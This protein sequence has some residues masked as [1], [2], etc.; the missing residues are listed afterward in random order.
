M[1]RHRTAVGLVVLLAVAGCAGSGASTDVGLT[2]T[3][4]PVPTDG[5]PTPAYR[6]APGL[7]ESGVVSPL[8]LASAH[9]ELLRSTA[10]HVRIDERTVGP[11]GPTTRRVL[12]GTFVNRTAYR[13]RVRAVSGNRTV[14]A[15]SLYADGTALYERHVTDDGVRY[16]LTNERLHDQSPYPPARLGSRT[17][18]DDLYIAFVGTSPDYVGTEVVDGSELHRIAATGATRPGLL[19]S[20]EYV[21]AISDYEFEALVTDAGFVRAYRVS[22]IAIDN[23]ERIRVDRRVRWSAVGNTTVPVP[24]WYEIARERTSE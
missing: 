22:Y 6:L 17:Q 14:L 13:I 4:A 5:T 19:A 12:E 3:P 10:F 16:Y 24:D 2:V 21:D 8:T 18:R 1:D 7:A 9:A 20:W 11:G 23:G 15:R